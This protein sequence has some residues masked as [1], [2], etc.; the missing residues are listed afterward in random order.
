MYIEKFL[1][2]HP[3][4]KLSK[5]IIAICKTGEKLMAQSPDPIHDHHHIGRLLKHLEIFLK[6][7][8]EKIDYSILLPA[9]CWHDVWKGRRQSLNPIK[10]FYY[11]IYEG[12]GSLKI[13]YHHNQHHLP[14]ATLKKIGYAIR[15]HSQFQFFPLKTIEAKILRDIDDLDILSAKRLKPLLAK[16]RYVSALTKKLGKAFLFLQTRP[17]AYKNSQ[18]IWTKKRLQKQT[19]IVQKLLN[20]L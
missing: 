18:F 16:R 20:W 5:K 1:Q 7:H 2:N 15:K 19:K 4:I 6:Q 13:F 17:S 9:I 8:Q 14:S 12:I 10:L 3:Q 11:Q